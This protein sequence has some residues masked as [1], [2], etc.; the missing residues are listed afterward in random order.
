MRRVTIRLS[1]A[2]ITFAVGLLIA[3]LPHFVPKRRAILSE[4][5]VEA[6]PTVTLDQAPYEVYP[7]ATTTDDFD[8]FWSEFKSA[9]ARDDKE[10]FYALVHCNEFSWEP[11]SLKLNYKLSAHVL[12]YYHV[13]K[14]YDEFARNYS[15][16]F[17]D[18]VKR[19]ILTREPQRGN[20]ASEYSIEWVE[21]KGRYKSAFTLMFSK[22]EGKGYKFMGMLEGPGY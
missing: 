16:I 15:D 4:P 6:P 11:S 12:N 3:S 14:N 5:N 1:I 9:V 20:S 18:F 10:T 19:A 21:G 22:V 2:A 7:E 8:Q 13:I 17:P